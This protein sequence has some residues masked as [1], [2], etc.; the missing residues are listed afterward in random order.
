[1]D[2]RNVV[3]AILDFPLRKKKKE[4]N[5]EKK[6][7]KKERKKNQLNERGDIIKTTKKDCPN[8]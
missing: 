7:E 5:I 3:C 6:K 8:S 2:C 4:I 1:M